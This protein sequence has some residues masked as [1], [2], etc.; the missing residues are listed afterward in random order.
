MMNFKALSAKLCE[1]SNHGSNALQILILYRSEK[2]Y[3]PI[4]A[5]SIGLT[6]LFIGILPLQLLDSSIIHFGIT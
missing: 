6:F 1:L 2:F 4:I 5:P 3:S